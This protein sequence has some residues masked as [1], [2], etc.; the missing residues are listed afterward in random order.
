M[1]I[2]NRREYFV[3]AHNYDANGD[4][5][6]WVWV[7][8]YSSSIYSTWWAGCWGTKS[9]MVNLLNDIVI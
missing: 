9:M 7:L 1:S 3:G 2:L 4:R 6:M 8:K 5:S